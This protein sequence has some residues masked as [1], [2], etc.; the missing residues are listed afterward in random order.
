MAGP[1][2][3]DQSSLGR[4]GIEPA[5]RIRSRL[6]THTQRHTLETILAVRD[7]AAT[8]SPARGDGIP[9][10]AHVLAQP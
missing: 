5:H 10:I 8:G 2:A 4:N 1:L 6:G 7:P 9:F 3:V